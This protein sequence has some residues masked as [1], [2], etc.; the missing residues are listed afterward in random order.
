M[1]KINMNRTRAKLSKN[2]NIVA[3]G[4][5]QKHLIELW[6]MVVMVVSLALG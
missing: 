2:I 3:V 4:P 5:W 6:L 1:Q